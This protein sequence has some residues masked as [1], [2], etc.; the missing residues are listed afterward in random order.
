MNTIIVR[1]QTEASIVKHRVLNECCTRKWLLN[2]AD[3]L[4]QL[5]G[6][7]DVS[8]PAARQVDI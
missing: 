5:G 4:E 6:Q 1:K 2:G 7:G 8:L 3:Y